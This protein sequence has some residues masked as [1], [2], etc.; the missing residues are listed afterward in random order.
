[1]CLKVAKTRFLVL[2]RS[3]K[4]RSLEVRDSIRCLYTGNPGAGLRRHGPVP[5]AIFR[6]LRALSVNQVNRVVGVFPCFD[7]VVPEECLPD[8]A[9]SCQDR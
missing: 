3:V 5:K 2:D 6:Q 4:N 9:G 7:E 1:M 8:P